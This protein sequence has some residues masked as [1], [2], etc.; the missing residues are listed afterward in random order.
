MAIV[1]GCVNVPALKSSRASRKFLVWQIFC[2]VCVQHARN[3][4]SLET[5]MIFALVALADETHILC[6]GYTMHLTS[7]LN[8]SALARKG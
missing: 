5:M 6:T 3:G 8:G 1:Q 4:D 2:V 7:F